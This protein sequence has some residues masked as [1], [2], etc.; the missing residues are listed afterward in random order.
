VLAA[1]VIAEIIVRIVDWRAG[2]DAT[3]YFPPP[4]ST[5]IVQPHPFLSF[6]QTPGWQSGGTYQRHINALGMR[7]K[8]IDAK[9]PAGVKRILCSGGSTTFCTGA[10]S[11]DKTWPAQLE[12]MLNQ[13]APESVRYEVG[14]V[15]VSGWTTIENLIDLELRRVELAPDYFIFYGAANDARPVQSIRDR[16]FEP[17]YTNLRR[18]WSPEELSPFE[19]FLVGHV[20][21]YA[22][23]SRGLDPE[24]QIGALSS[25]MFVPGYE[26][27]HVRSDERVNEIGV[28]AYLR[29]VRHMVLVC[30]AHDIQPVLCTFAQCASR[31]K[32]TDDRFVETVT[33][34]NRGLAE[35]A[36]QEHVPLIDIARELSDKPVY[37]DDW[38][39][40][41]DNG[42][43]VFAKTLVTQARAQGLFA[44]K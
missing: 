17:D 34:M 16:E 35:L 2:R 32:P 5:S 43:R 20:R 13:S 9:K 27:L 33:S 41:N 31:L 12:V 39:H 42:C 21:T 14:N 15:G 40:H 6:T 30:R 23:L 24:K 8:E 19:T 11:D 10:T 1:L 4:A 38:I 36:A 44:S 22:W 25:H 26:K 28:A 29:N 18:A 37:Y 7:G 3:F